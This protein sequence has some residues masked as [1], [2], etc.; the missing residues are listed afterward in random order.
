MLT[1]WDPAR[2]ARIV[3]AA[4]AEW[5]RTVR[6][7]PIGDADDI[8]AYLRACGFGRADEYAADGDAEWCG[9]FAAAC[10]VAA[11]A[12]PEAVRV[13]SSPEVGDFAST[14][15]LHRLCASD[16]RRRIDRAEDLRPGDVAIVGRVG[17]RAWGEHVTIVE[18]RAGGREFA[19]VEGNATGRLGDGSTGEGVV[20]RVRM[21]LPTDRVRGFIFGVRLTPDDYIAEVSHGAE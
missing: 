6:E 12:R 10:H 9:A 11:G 8:R 1:P 18:G 14:Y 17:R 20:R 4:L 7:P 16:P 3:E 21:V 15:R 13:K 19:T 2:G 5:R